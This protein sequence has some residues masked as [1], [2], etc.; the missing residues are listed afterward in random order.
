MVNSQPAERDELEKKLKAVE[1]ELQ[2][3]HAEEVELTAET[4]R[5]LE[6]LG[7]LAGGHSDTDAENV[8]YSALH[9]IEEMIPVLDML[10]E[11]MAL[12][13]DGKTS[14]Q[15]I[16][17]LQEVI[18]LSPESFSFHGRLVD[19]LVKAGRVQE[20][21]PEALEYHRL[22]PGDPDMCQTV[23]TS[24]IYLGRPAEAVPYF[25]K[26]ISLK[27]DFALPH[28]ELAKLLRASGDSE[29][30][31]RHSADNRGKLGPASE[32]YELGVVL[33]SRQRFDEAVERFNEALKVAP[34]DA[35][36]HTGLARVL[37]QKG[38]YA[39]AAREYAE[40]VR[41]DPADPQKLGDW[42]K[43]LGESGQIR[44]SGGASHQV[45][46]AQTRRCSGAHQPRLGA[47]AAGQAR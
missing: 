31:D 36:I 14:E 5:R 8:D 44:R 16:K 21:L 46:R 20:A 26:A 25:W 3:H 39:E 12:G 28:E 24:Y 34:G 45:R 19:A 2:V 1:S 37:E 9:D 10:P 41:L 22:K 35:L 30:A 29:G 11:L 27:A 42:G 40:A 18:R 6:A 13:R 23:A 7:Y 17:G 43:V 4:V 32:Q 38:D 15:L 47:G 33:G